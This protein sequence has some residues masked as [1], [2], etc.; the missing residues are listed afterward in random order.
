MSLLSAFLVH[1]FVEIPYFIFPIIVLAV[2]EDLDFGPYMWIGLGTLGTFS[3]LA[4]GL[5]SP[6]F[7]WLSD[8][9][10]RGSMMA[11]SL[12][13]SGVGA[14]IIAFFGYSFIGLALGIILL[15][16]AISLYHP[17]GLSWVS[18]AFVNPEEQSYSSYFNR[19]L[20][21]HGVGGTIGAALAPLSIYLLID[22]I[23]WRQIYFI[24]AIPIFIVAIGFWAFVG[25]QEPQIELSTS[26]VRSIREFR[27]FKRNSTW[28]QSLNSTVLLIFVF[29][30]LM[31]LTWG[32]TSFILSPFLS[33]VK[34]FKISQAALFIGI[35]H[36][37]GASGQVIGGILGDKYNEK[38]A[39]SVAA[40]LQAFVLIGV[41]I[42]THQIILFTLYITL[43]IVNAI[44]WPSTNSFLAKNTKRRGSAFG[45][46]MLIVNVVRAL[47]PSIDGLLITFDPS[48]YFLIFSFATLFSMAAFVTLL[49]VKSNSKEKF[50]N[51]S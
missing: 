24:W 7:G 5:P 20:G 37:I 14:L 19:I 31:S 44:F 33:E 42:F 27:I 18:A 30:F 6:L 21:L 1:A 45:G 25:R 13:L 39:L 8:R 11:L 28:K 32:M 46:F 29:M 17:P 47:G 12:V 41:Y 43:F 26:D 35:S 36:L 10:R 15:G 23:H 3:T 2:G 4:A 22:F 40:I 48:N 34:Y 51:Y 9:Y 50:E 49:P 16:I 38:V